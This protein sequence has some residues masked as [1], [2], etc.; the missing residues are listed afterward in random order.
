MANAGEIMSSPVIAID[1]SKSVREAAKVMTMHS[2]GCLVVREGE[3]MAG[4]ITER[5]LLK[6]V[7]AVSRNPDETK[8]SEVMSTKIITVDARAD[9]LEVNDLLYEHK[10]RWLP[11]VADGKVVGIITPR[12]IMKNLRRI[13]S[14]RFVGKEYAQPDYNW[15]ITENVRGE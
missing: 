7:A 4:I 14:R 5:D 12:N 13:R 8:V 2:I 10:I 15:H 1:S 9:L 3:E 6:K 11:V